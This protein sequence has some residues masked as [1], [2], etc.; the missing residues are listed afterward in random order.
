MGMSDVNER[1]LY[2][3]H[4]EWDTYVMGLDE[5]DAVDIAREEAVG[6]E[7]PEQSWADLVT[8]DKTLP[9][10]WEGC[11]PWG[12]DGK[13]YMKD[14][15]KRLPEPEPKVEIQAACSRCSKNP[16][17]C[18]VSSRLCQGC[19]NVVVEI[20]EKA[21]GEGRSAF[22]AKQ[23]RDANP[24][25]SSDDDEGL[26][27]VHWDL[28]WTDAE[29]DATE[30]PK[31]DSTVVEATIRITAPPNPA[32]E[33][34]RQFFAYAHLP[35]HLQQI[36]KAFH[37]LAEVVASSSSNPETTVALRKLLEGNDAAVRAVM[38]EKKS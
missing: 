27:R 32:V 9:E 37:D 13:T 29:Q 17:G 1:K 11:L 33:H 35:P 8:K 30:E 36:S 2:K 16:A 24:Y 31:A 10:S 7:A 18:P 20:Q 6:D 34:V 14:L 22:N 12:G 5:D 26:K 15:W 19:A 25:K 3:V 21:Y 4:L 28:G 23:A 38:I